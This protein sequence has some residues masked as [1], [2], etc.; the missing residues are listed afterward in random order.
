MRLSEFIIKEYQ[1]NTFWESTLSIPL[2]DLFQWVIRHKDSDYTEGLVYG[3]ASLIAEEL[4]SEY[5]ELHPEKES[6]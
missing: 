6:A 2:E 3:S 5:T 4:Y 1:A